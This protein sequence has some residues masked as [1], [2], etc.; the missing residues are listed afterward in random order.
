[1]NIVYFMKLKIIKMKVEDFEMKMYENKKFVSLVDES[2]KLKV[3]V[4]VEVFDK[5]FEKNIDSLMFEVEMII[6]GLFD[7]VVKVVKFV[8]NDESYD[9][10]LNGV[11]YEFDF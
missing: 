11:K 7:D 8:S 5:V 1:M 3:E 2:R 6:D 10:Y 4:D 9:V